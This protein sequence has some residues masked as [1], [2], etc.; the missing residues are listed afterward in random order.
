V[1][2]NGGAVD[3][4]TWLG[5]A[6]P[7]DL[8]RDRLPVGPSGRQLRLWACG[9]ARLVWRLLDDGARLLVEGAERWVDP[10]PDVAG[11]AADSAAGPPP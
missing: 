10:G 4:P 8:L 5:C 2:V 1:K 6:D 9:C 7:R 11:E 3:E